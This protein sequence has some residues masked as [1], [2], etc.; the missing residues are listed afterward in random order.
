M[1]EAGKLRTEKDA[2]ADAVPGLC[3]RDVKESVT[4]TA[5]R[6]KKLDLAFIK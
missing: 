3:E 4:S 5:P 1:N 2:H 6:V